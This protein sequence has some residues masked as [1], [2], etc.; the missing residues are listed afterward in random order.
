LA[1]EDLHPL[2]HLHRFEEDHAEEDPEED[3]ADFP[4]DLLADFSED[5]VFTEDF[6]E[7]LIGSPLD[8]LTT[9]LTDTGGSGQIPAEFPDILAEI[10]ELPAEF[11]EVPAEFPEVPAEIPEVL[12]FNVLHPRIVSFHSCVSCV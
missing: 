3:L 4:E 8:H 12:H 10:P 1:L 5:H 11:P 2:L 7:D 6:P 9:D